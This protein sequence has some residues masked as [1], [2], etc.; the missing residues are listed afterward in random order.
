MITYKN[1]LPQT[2]GVGYIRPAPHK[3]GAGICTPLD[4]KAHNRASGFFTCDASPQPF[5]IMAGR[6]GEPKGSPV[7]FVPGSANPVRLATPSFAPLGGGG[8]SSSNKGYPSWQT[9]N[10]LTLTLSVSIPGPKS[11]IA[12][13]AQ[14]NWHGVSG[15]NPSPKT[16]LRWRCVFRP[17]SVIWLTI[18]ATFTT[19]LTVKSATR[20][21]SE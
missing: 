2:A 20:N 7:S 21:P 11:I 15:L 1:C 16:A 13:T 19:C 8:T 9:A 10:I 12:C 14:K 18:Y 5:R 3:T 4:T 6:M 17:F